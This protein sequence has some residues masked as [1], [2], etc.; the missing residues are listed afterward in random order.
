M[1][2]SPQ[3]DAEAQGYTYHLLA[4]IETLKAAGAEQ[5]AA[6]HWKA[7]TSTPINVALT[8]DG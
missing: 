1:S 6:E 2:E 3:V 8:R 7:C 4:G 5:R